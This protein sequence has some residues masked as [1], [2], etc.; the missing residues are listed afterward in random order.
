MKLST[1]SSSR[2][3]SRRIVANVVFRFARAEAR[4]SRADDTQLVANGSNFLEN[5]CV[6]EQFTSTN[7]P[8]VLAD[9]T[10]IWTNDGWLRRSSD[11]ADERSGEDDDGSKRKAHD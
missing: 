8:A 3:R 7:L 10:V 2:R 6:G 5:T 1:S 4:P 9:V 11:E